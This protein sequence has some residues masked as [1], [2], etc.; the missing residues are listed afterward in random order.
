MTG[1]ILCFLSMN[2]C[3]EFAILMI[4]YLCVQKSKF[5]IR[6]KFNCDVNIDLLSSNDLLML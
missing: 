3:C 1:D 4:L 2:P 6:L 5:V